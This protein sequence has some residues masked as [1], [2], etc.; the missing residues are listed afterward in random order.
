MIKMKKI[1]PKIS[2]KKRLKWK[3]KSGRKQMM[4]K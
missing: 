4:K 1:R 3:Q 2:K